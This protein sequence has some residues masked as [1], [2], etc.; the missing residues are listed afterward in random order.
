MKNIKRLLAVLVAVV[1]S[2]LFISSISLS[3][4]DN[5][6]TFTYYTQQEGVNL[7]RLNVENMPKAQTFNKGVKFTHIL[8]PKSNNYTFNY[9][10]YY[11]DDVE[12]I[13]TVGDTFNN[14]TSFY[15]V[16]SPTLRSVTYNLNGGV[17]NRYN[18]FVFYGTNDVLLEEPTKEGYVF[19]GWYDN[20]NFQ[21]SP[22]TTLGDGDK[23][24]K[25]YAKWEGIEYTV[26]FVDYDNKLID[27]QVIV[28]GE[29]AI[30]PSVS[31]REGYTFIGWDTDFSSVTSDLTIKALYEQNEFTVTFV[32]Y[33]N[34][35]LD[36]QTVKYGESATVSNE[37]N[38]KEGYHFK[39]WDKDF[40]NIKGDLTVKAIY[41]INKY[42]VKFVDFDDT[43]L[44]T[45]TV[46][47]GSSAE[48]IDDPVRVGY[49]FISWDKEFNNITD[50]LTIKA[51]YEINKYIVEFVDYD[52][53]LLD[54]QVVEH[55]SF[56]EAIDEPERVGYS[57]SGW[58]KPL[59][60]IT[61]N[62]TIKAT[63]NI[64]QYT[65]TFNSNGGSLVDSITQ[66]YDTVIITPDDPTKIGYQFIRW[67]KDVPTK[68]PAED[69]SL[70]SEW[71]AIS[72]NI[73]YK[74]LEE[75]ENSN[76]SNY[77]IEDEFE[78]VDLENRPSHVF[79]GWF[80]ALEDGNNI[81]KI[82]EG[83][84]G[85]QTIY[86][87]WVIRKYTVKFID[88]DEEVLNE[89]T[90]DYGNSAETPDDPVR[91]GFNF[92]SWDRDFSNITYNLNVYALY[93]ASYYITFDL[94]NE[95]YYGT[96]R[97]GVVDEF[98]K[99]Y[100]DFY[101]SVIEK[102]INTVT[103]LLEN[104]PGFDASTSLIFRLD[105]DA[106]L[107]A[108]FNNNEIHSKWV[109]LLEYIKDITINDKEAFNELINKNPSEDFL[110]GIKHA[111]VKYEL[112]AFLSKR[113]HSGDWPT[114]S[115][116]YTNHDNA[117]GFW[118]T[119]PYNK[120]V[121][122]Y[123]KAKEYFIGEEVFSWKEDRVFS[124]WTD[125]NNNDVTEYPENFAGSTTYKAVWEN[126]DPKI[127]YDLGNY[128]YYGIENK[129][130]LY[131]DFVTDYKDLYG[132]TASTVEEI[133]GDFA[134]KTY[135]PPATYH[136]SEIFSGSY[137]YG[138]WTWLKDYIVLIAQQQ[139]YE[140]L[141]SLYSYDQSTWRTNIEAF[142]NNKQFVFST[143]Y[144][145]LDFTD[146]VTANDF[147]KYTTYHQKVVYYKDVDA[148]LSSEVYSW[149]NGYEFVGWYD[150]NNNLVATLPS[151]L[152]TNLRLFAKFEEKD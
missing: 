141:G 70:T 37:P 130:E 59:T 81:T 117:N 68:M 83:T 89:Q 14:D 10:V 92:T 138:K 119:S 24:I 102:S 147:W 20:V 17:N 39:K 6:V 48:R 115:G 150:A 93:E 127:Y 85:T 129:V 3:A 64:N 111:T 57:F 146:D 50:N 97:Q 87:R 128:G 149:H 137:K 18:P 151:T 145:S 21:G 121:L 120:A 143:D 84:T 9:W 47:H 72:Y 91:V 67:D 107:V 12:H 94:G 80:D 65:I 23:S 148:L 15:A 76:P 123:D 134:A 144:T 35:V 96:N 116:D 106:N 135:I 82:E 28:H 78:L 8:K 34:D 7:K 88:K 13:L 55:G 54:T 43:V 66:D 74:N 58:D 109:W 99:D 112:W 122:D 5:K 42:T 63:Y 125:I 27:T 101:N 136:I 61:S 52:H 16:W 46:E 53:E 22:Y 139:N 40:S 69:L 95:G 152:S 29:S 108:F 114:S 140:R 75:V 49:K 11:V 32:D 45:Q 133:M 126:D 31:E 33:N 132:R 30:A 118:P 100:R 110:E 2:L 142:F 79:V 86:A 1:A 26:S 113:K 124:K 62:L 25:L 71:E 56:A 105:T 103:L 19:L 38:N 104:E 44:S 90:V 60:N 41:E 73:E 77:T 51:V 131:R 98:L 4:K 36:V